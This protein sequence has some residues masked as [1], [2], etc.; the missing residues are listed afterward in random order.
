MPIKTFI[1]TLLLF[2]NWFL[3][4]AAKTQTNKYSKPLDFAFLIKPIQKN[5]D[6]IYFT[7]TTNGNFGK[8]ADYYTT[9]S[10]QKRGLITRK[11]TYYTSI[12]IKPNGSD[13]E[14]YLPIKDEVVDK[15]LKK[16]IQ[17]IESKYLLELRLRGI[18]FKNY[19]TI[20]NSP[21]FIIDEAEQ[22]TLK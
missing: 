3:P 22:V 4:L 18:R 12:L 16:L 8:S 1:S 5:T 10:L 20:R 9:D 14:L 13:Q 21:F 6:T 15:L 17:T 11:D 19:E 7:A 2:I